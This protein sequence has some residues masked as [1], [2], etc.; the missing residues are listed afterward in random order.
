M[1]WSIVLYSRSLSW[2]SIQRYLFSYFNYQLI[3]INIHKIWHL[4]N[5]QQPIQFRQSK[6]TKHDNEVTRIF[7][8]RQFF[9][10]KRLLMHEDFPN[11][12]NL[13]KFDE[14]KIS[15]TNSLIGVDINSRSDDIQ[16]P[17][18]SSSSLRATY[19]S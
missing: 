15:P 19:S 7:R 13:E 9:F 2:S 12:P 11:P 4:A 14:S 16:H 18:S 5:Y 3:S 1:S 6:T 17:S 8:S 10:R